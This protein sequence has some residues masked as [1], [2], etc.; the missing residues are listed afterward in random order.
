MQNLLSLGRPLSFRKSRLGNAILP[1][2]SPSLAITSSINLQSHISSFW[3]CAR[4]LSVNDVN[5]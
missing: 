1:I 2:I 4:P 3:S 5:R